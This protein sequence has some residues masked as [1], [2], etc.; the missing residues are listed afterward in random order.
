MEHV[1]ITTSLNPTYEIQDES[2]NWAESELQE[3]VITLFGNML[4]EFT[5]TLRAN[6][7]DKTEVYWLYNKDDASKKYIK[8]PSAKEVEEQ[9][10]VLFRALVKSNLPEL[11]KENVIDW[12]SSAFLHIAF[13]STSN[14]IWEEELLEISAQLGEYV[15]PDFY[16]YGSH[17]DCEDTIVTQ[18]YSEGEYDTGIINDFDLETYGW[19]N[20][21]GMVPGIT[22][23]MFNEEYYK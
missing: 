2:Q 13:K 10:A 12:D 14:E 19:E 17:P 21:C 15:K 11:P 20:N 6:L 9:G 4:Y 22:L 7:S 1:F 8:L 16:V 23:E 18:G 5:Q 3:N